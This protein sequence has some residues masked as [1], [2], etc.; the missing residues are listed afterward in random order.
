LGIYTCNHSGIV[1]KNCRIVG[2]TGGIELIYS[3][4]SL[5]SN[6]TLWNNN[7]GISLLGSIGDEVSGNEVHSNTD[8]G[9]FIISSPSI[10]EHNHFIQ[11]MDMVYLL[12]LQT[13]AQSSIIQ[14][15]IMN[16]LV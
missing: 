11:M 6:N 10:V 7:G 8:F 3:S 16:W 15:Q 4:S 9:I 12:H 2:Y 5:I 1:I 13:I 14:Y